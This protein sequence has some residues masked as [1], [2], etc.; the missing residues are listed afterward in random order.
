MPEPDPST[1][2]S[3]LL[4]DVSRRERRNVLIASTVGTLMAHVGLVPT[5]ISAL[6]IAF[7]APAQSSLLVL[8]AIVVAYFVAAFFIYGW[9]D[10]LIWRKRRH[11]YVV[12]LKI[13][14]DNWTMDDEMELDR[15]N[16]PSIAWYF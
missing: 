2:L 8:M 13:A 15:L 10:F 14:D 3:D 16:V 7:P 1:F 9:A 11:D 6:G 12:S 5:Q 4:S